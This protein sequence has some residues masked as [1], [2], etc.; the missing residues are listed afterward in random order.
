[1]KKTL[2][3][4]IAMIGF[5]NVSLAQCGTIM[6]NS[7]KLQYPDTITNL[8]IAIINSDYSAIIQLF[9]YD[10]GP[11]LWDDFSIEGL[12]DSFN[13]SAPRYLTFSKPDGC[14]IIFSSKVISQEGT[15]PI[16]INYRVY[17]GQNQNSYYRSILGYIIKV[18][19]KLSYTSSAINVN[20]LAKTSGSI[21]LN[22]KGGTPPYQYAINNGPFQ[23]SNEFVNLPIGI[24]TSKVKDSLNVIVQQNDTIKSLQGILSQTMA[25]PTSVASSATANYLVG[26]QIGY[27]FAWEITN[28]I[29]ASGQGAN[30]A[31]VIWAQF[32]GQGNIKVKATSPTTGC[33]DTA[34]LN[35]TIGST[36]ISIIGQSLLCTI[37]PNPA[38]D[39]LIISNTQKLN[40][41]HI[42]IYD[43]IGRKMLE[44]NITS[45]TNEHTVLVSELKSG[46]YILSIQKEGETSRIK[47][48][49]E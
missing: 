39:E 46:A 17:V 1:M 2:Y 22:A 41:S 19:P 37:Y 21:T 45:V 24:Y 44:E 18:N 32:K 4:L 9:K 47:F 30:S 40:G 48:V 35:V 49:K 10:A 34:M 42:I 29:I 31:Q 27:S 15:F 26:Q 12:P 6:V 13:Y 36:N 5:A 28:G 38:K 20:C 33:I 3:T 25:G 7:G 14:I 43:M 8:P 11:I 16:K 23:S